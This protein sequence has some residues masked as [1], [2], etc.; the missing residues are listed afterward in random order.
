MTE[1]SPALMRVA[2]AWETTR[3]PFST[4]VRE[5]SSA[6]DEANLKTHYVAVYLGI[7]VATLEGVIQLGLLE[8]GALTLLDE[9]IPRTAYLQ[10]AQCS[11]EEIE[12][13][14]G[15]LRAPSTDGLAPSERVDT[16]L[17]ETRGTPTR[18]L[19]GELSAELFMHFAKKAVDYGFLNEKER[20]AL[21]SFGK[22]RKKGQPLTI[23]QAEWA[24]KML[25]ELRDRGAIRRDS[26]DSD[27]GLCDYALDAI[28][29]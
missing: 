17:R 20:K 24:T 10:L 12:L 1:A 2:E 23:K 5:I 27:Q 28:G 19:V 15:I 18:E 9:A 6:V 11:P 21:A 4:W 22:W 14:V 16:I 26:P 29:D 25:V 3:S 7:T 13:V 8:D